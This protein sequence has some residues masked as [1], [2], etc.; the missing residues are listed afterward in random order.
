MKIKKVAVLGSGVMGSGIA[1]HVASAGCEVEL[2]DIVIDEA[3]PDKLA[4]GALEALKKSRPALAMHANYLKKIRPGNL[5]DHLDRI[6]D[7]DWVVEVVKEDLTIK[8]VLYDRVEPLL[9]PGAWVSSN[10]S[11]IPLK[12][13][14]EGRGDSFRKHFVITHFFNPVRYL[15]LLEFVKGPE[16]DAGEAAAFGTWLEEILGKE[17]VPAFDSPTFIGNR[18]GIHSIMTVMHLAIREAIP[19]EVIDSVL[20]EAAGRAKSAS[21]RTADLAGVDILAATAK[22]VFDLCPADEDRDIFRFPEFLQ[23][24]LD[25]KI[26]GNKVKGGFFK[27]GGKDEKG[28]PIFLSLNSETKE[29]RVQIRKD[30]PLLKELKGIEDPAERVRA[31]FT[32]DTEAGRLAWRSVAPNLA[33]AV[34]RLGEVTDGPLNVDRALKNGFAMEIGPFELWDALGVERVA[35][36]ME[37]EEIKVPELVKR[38]LAKGVTSFYRWEHGLPTAQLNP[39]T[40][41]F[42]PILEDKRIMVLK[43]EEARGKVIAENSSAQLID[44]GDDVACLSFRTKMNALDDGI[45]GLMEDAIQKHIPGRFKG[46]VV[47]NQGAHFS[48]GANLV[49]VLNAAK[50]KR[51]DLIHEVGRRL[52]YAGRMLTYAPFPTVAAP[53]NL[54]L[55][56]GCEVTMAAQRVVGHAELYIGLVEVGVGV[57]PAGGGCLQLLLRMEEALGQKERGPMPKVKAA[58]QYIAT[59][60]V[61]TSFDE[62]QRA[63]FLRR[64]D[65]RVMNKAF[66]LFEAKNE[67]LRMAEAF[68]PVQER[69]LRLPGRGGS[70]ALKLAVKDFQLQGKA[71]EYDGVVLGELAEVLCGGDVSP[72][73]EIT[74]E[75]ILELEREAFVRLCGHE[76]TQARMEHI[77]QKGKPLRN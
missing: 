49:M 73:Q 26:F 47:G 31:L 6:Q 57:I 62:A 27:K 18:I 44:L 39:Q 19:F 15:R 35:A 65:R 10:T 36:R 21:F 33:Y 34:N 76:K 32:S 50:D 17:V 55:G 30:W 4:A 2:L 40:L 28:K 70:E 53:F 56:G 66:V 58:F 5:R 60:T 61:H 7:C 63:G 12:M 77:L 72:V 38:M 74:E 29:Y 23:W 37:F 64:T 51:F 69:T 8:R 1:A 24:M 14:T 20:G 16:V 46:L 9:K 13:L 59:A 42:D 22:N 41:A 43:R 45:I 3:A 68:Q 54:A 25:N 71:T 75:R 11:G 52:Q 48:A 67:V